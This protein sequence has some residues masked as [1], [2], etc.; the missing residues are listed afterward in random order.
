MKK[1]LTTI[2]LLV[3]FYSFSQNH[4]LGKVTVAELKERV[5]PIDTSA[6]AA[7]LFDIG[8]T[9][10]GYDESG[11]YS[12]TEVQTKIKIYKKEGLNFANKS[13]G[14]YV[15][16]DPVEIVTFS[17]AVTYN[18]KGNEIEKTR[19]KSDGEF[20]EK[21]SKTTNIKKITFPN[22]KE[23]SI[24]EFKYEIKSSYFQ[25]FR[26][27]RFQTVIPTV[28][29]EY[30]TSIPEYY[31]YNPMIKGSLTP[32]IIESAGKNTFT[33]F[34][35][36]RNEMGSPYRKTLNTSQNIEFTEKR[37]TY[38]LENVPALKD[39]SY[40]NNIENYTSS[41]VHELSG[42]QYPGEVFRPIT[43]S[44][45]SVSKSI[46]DNEM[47]GGELNKDSYFEDDL[48]VIINGV[49]SNDERLVKVFDYVKS[50]MNW[51]E[52]KRVYCD[53]GVKTA[54][55]NMIGNSAEINLILVAMLR[56]AGVNANPILISTRDNGISIFPSKTA[57][58]YVIAGVET[59]GQMVLL[60]ATNKNSQPN[61]L[62]IR[63]L[64]WFGRIIRKNGSSA[65]I[66]LM[67]QSN[68]KDVVNIIAAIN[69]Q[70]E[71]TGKIREQYFD[72]NAF[73][74]RD[75]YNSIS[76]DSYIEKL[77]KRHQGLEIGEFDVQNSKDL[78]LPI[79]ENYSF[80]STNSVEVI[81]DKMYISPLLFFASTENPFKQ[82]TREYPIDFVYPS[83]DKYTVSLTIPEGYAVETLPQ[84]KALSMP[85]N[86][87]GFKYMIS[88][89]GSLVQL[90][91]TQ[92]NN[93]AI[94]ASEAY[95]V[96]K[97]YYKEIVSKQTE[98]IVLKKI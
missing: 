74:Y 72:Y 9:S 41:V 87:G 95:Q 69:S 32:K 29:S 73:V 48:K 85:G 8:K 79:V 38:I 34:D 45:E 91:Y 57:Y 3:T 30:K 16:K 96:L 55:K 20:T 71:V 83:Q 24:I 11:F 86:L 10:F 6:V 25:G 50:K 61:I 60:D 19:L 31:F 62:P 78:S 93:Q 82:E 44:W 46:Y 47:F 15:G 63:D 67:P 65:E 49:A 84:S 39:E 80:K 75:N 12:L 53:D 22:V 43:N 64:N 54:Y 92:D 59:N 26:D 18:L 2:L 42:I 77:E 7:V 81:G 66:N 70:G 28:Y 97:D 37:R 27:W 40:V 36:D 58:N 5:C 68:S 76:K 51:D 56:K 17:K 94:I 98:K 14:Y 23:G 89:N 33:Y 52:Y 90:V 35:R 1:V 13:V 21:L 4:E 88:N